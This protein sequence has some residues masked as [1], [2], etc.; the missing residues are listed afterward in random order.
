MK[1]PL[2][3]GIEELDFEEEKKDVATMLTSPRVSARSMTVMHKK[4]N[5]PQKMVSER[6]DKFASGKKAELL[7]Q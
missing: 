7:E 3:L 2:L 4:T 6:F 5:N 1:K